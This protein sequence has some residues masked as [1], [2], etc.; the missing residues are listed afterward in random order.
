MWR[1]GKW[2]CGTGRFHLASQ[3]YVG[4][5]REKEGKRYIARILSEQE[6]CLAMP[7][8]K[9]M[10]ISPSKNSNELFDSHCIKMILS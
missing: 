7:L 8:A 3:L 10:H 6:M 9:S 4:S 1:D 5:H 2:C